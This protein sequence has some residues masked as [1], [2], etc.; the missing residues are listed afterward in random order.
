[1]LVLGTG[2]GEGV[3]LSDQPVQRHLGGLFVVGLTYLAQDVYYRLDLLEVLLAE[4]SPHTPHEAQGPV[5][6]RT[7]L[8]GKEAFSDGAVGDECHAQIPA[9]FEHPV[10]LRCPLQ[11]AVL[12]LVR[13]ERHPVRGEPVV[14]PLHLVRTV[15][16]Y[17]HPADLARLDSLRE[18]IHQAVYLE[19]RVREVDLVEVYR[20][21]T[22]S[23]QTL[24]N[25]LQKR[26]GAEAVREGG[27]LGGY[28]WPPLETTLAQDLADDPL[29]RAVAVH[30]RRVHEGDAL[31]HART[32]GPPHVATVVLFAISPEPGRTPR[33]GTDTQR[34]DVQL[35]RKTNCKLALQS[36]SSHIFASRFRLARR[37]GTFSW[38]WHDLRICAKL[39]LPSH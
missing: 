31:G 20:L 15:V 30:L 17:A 19:N 34:S 37:I 11:E 35:I 27:E 9:R 18:C 32:E 33:P 13:G 23:L 7:I 5:A 38:V 26:I 1:M 3:P 14:R 10:C 28:D 21:Y 2:D 22:E 12:Y 4:G 8:A 6:T 36:V 39:P 29:R 25:R 24:V 16:A